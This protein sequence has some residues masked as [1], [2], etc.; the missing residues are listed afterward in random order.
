VFQSLNSMGYLF[1]YPHTTVLAD[2]VM[3]SHYCSHL[4]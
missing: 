2:E 3:A 1:T 4:L